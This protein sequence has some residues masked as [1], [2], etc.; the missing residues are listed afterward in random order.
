MLVHLAMMLSSASGWHLGGD[1]HSDAPTA[2]DAPT[3]CDADWSVSTP[4]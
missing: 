4:A 2:S 1:A 3:S